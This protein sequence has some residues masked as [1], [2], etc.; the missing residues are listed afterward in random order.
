MSCTTLLVGKKASLT[1]ATL[2][3]RNDDCSDHAFDPKKI[4]VVKPE[5]QPREYTSK[6]TGVH[7]QLPDNPLRYTAAPHVVPDQGVW[8]AAGVNAANVAMTA[9]ET[10]TS[11]D[12]VRG[13]D[14]LLTKADGSGPDGIGEEDFIVITLP[15]IRSAR[16]GVLRLGDL[17]RTYGTYEMNGIAFQDVNEIWWFETIGG[18][19]WMAARVPDDRYVVMP[20]QLGIDHFDFNDAAGAQKNYMCSPDLRQ[21]VLDHQLDPSMD[22]SVRTTGI[23]NPRLIFG[24]HEDADHVYNTPRAWDMERYLNPSTSRWYGAEADFTPVSDNIPWS[25]VPERKLSVIDVKNALS[26]HYQNTAFD[27]Y[28][29]G[30]EE[31]RHLYRPTGINRTRYYCCVELRPDLPEEIRAIQWI[32]FGSNVFNAIVPIYSNAD[33]M[34]A[35]IS[36]TTTEVDPARNFYW[37]NRLIGVLADIRYNDTIAMVE[38]YQ[39]KVQS[40]G[41]SMLHEHDR[42]LCGLLQEKDRNGAPEAEK[43]EG[44]APRLEEAN[45]EM[46]LFTKGETGKLLSQ[47]LFDTSLKMHNAFA[48]SDV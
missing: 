40:A 1:G 17:I 10:I 14:P 38:R 7:L 39:T 16:E 3:A 43:Q 42:K 15:Y 13:A 44:I 4:I 2:A 34:P 19:H 29:K 9:T 31:S 21:F 25:R 46:L 24:S 41:L 33:R 36:N 5:D 35:Y 18:H 20:N 28:G 23:C 45:E 48:R 27:P 6:I 47:L 30:P 8:A 11:N 37:A 32:S 26:L 12:E 22:E